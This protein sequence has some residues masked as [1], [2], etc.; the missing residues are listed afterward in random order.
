MCRHRARRGVD[1][2]AGAYICFG[3]QVRAAF[4]QHHHHLNV[5]HAYGTVQRRVASLRTT[6]P[7]LA[8]LH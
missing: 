7:T 3:L 4:H 5:I 2:A 1:T 8:Q 6:A